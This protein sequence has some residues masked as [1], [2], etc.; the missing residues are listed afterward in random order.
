MSSY[1]FPAASSSSGGLPVGAVVAGQ[2]TNLPT[3]YLP[4]DGSSYLKTAYPLLDTTG[5]ETLGSNQLVTRTMPTAAQWTQV[6]GVAG[7]TLIAASGST[8]LAKSIDGGTTWATIVPPVGG[9]VPL[10]NTITYLNSEWFIPHLNQPIIYKSSDA[11]VTWSAQ[12]S[13]GVCKNI[14]AIGNN[15][16]IDNEG[17]TGNFF[18]S[19]T[20][21]TGS[22]V[23]VIP[24]GN[25]N[26]ST[27]RS[28]VVRDGVLVV[29]VNNVSTPGALYSTDGVTFE[30]VPLLQSA[31]TVVYDSEYI[32]PFTKSRWFFD[33]YIGDHGSSSLTKTIYGDT[34]GTIGTLIGGKSMS[35]GHTYGLKSIALVSDSIGN[36]GIS[37]DSGDSWFNVLQTPFNFGVAQGIS[38]RQHQRFYSE[39]GTR[40]FFT[41]NT[42]S[43]TIATLDIDTT[44]FHT[45]VKPGYFIKVT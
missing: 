24:P 33:H 7:G 43:T 32:T 45:P 5:L 19:S 27:Y 41:A 44:K 39:L 15:L 37:Y 22:W 30:K 1:Q 9:T 2:L 38:A 4:C 25:S 6:A 10:Q 17:Y 11:G 31:V 16:V 8:V 18:R 13:P 29:A 12:T 34:P 20:G 35:Y 28:F 26:A 36:L 40:G 14:V 21:V 23:T 3:G 42:V